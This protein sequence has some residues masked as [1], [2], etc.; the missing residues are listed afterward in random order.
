[1]SKGKSFDLKENPYFVYM[2]ESRKF[3]LRYSPEP[4]NNKSLIEKY[5]KS[6][7]PINKTL[8]DNTDELN[9]KFKLRKSLENKKSNEHELL[10]QRKNNTDLVQNFSKNY[11]TKKAFRKT[12]L[13]RR[14]KKSPT[15]PSKEFNGA[16]KS[17]YGKKEP[18]KVSIT[19]ETNSSHSSGKFPVIQKG[20]SIEDYLLGD[21]L[22]KGGYA[23]VRS[24]IHSPTGKV[25]A[26][27]V[28]NKSFLN[29]PSRL[30][31]LEKE[32]A[33]MKSLDHPSIVK[34]H[35]KIETLTQVIIVM[36]FVSSKS[37]LTHIKNKREKLLNEAEAKKIFAQLMDAINYCHQKRVA[38]RDVKLENILLDTN[39][40]AKLIDFGF[41]TA[42]ENG[43]K[44]SMFCGTPNYMAPEIVQHKEFSPAPADIWACGVVL[45]A[46]LYGNYPFNSKNKELYRK[47]TKQEVLLKKTVSKE[48][49]NLIRKMLHK[50]PNERPCAQEVLNHKWLA[51]Y[52]GPD[53]IDELLSGIK[54][55]L[56]VIF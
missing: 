20:G 39:N 46:M 35:Q 1:M 51:N 23:V 2:P 22:G 14:P 53:K 40:N 50:D 30:K 43:E 52:K 8:I 55:K 28:Y 6:L 3:K 27:K 10:T 11:E 44:M 41:S 13:F 19:P 37:L 45:F 21:I 38:H 31:S 9:K 54:T 18:R 29:K 25:F 7:K 5:R 47:I 15:S 48:A 17:L 24:A 36:E 34:F 56:K 49:R 4:T 33:V 26:L 12:Q 32:I 42:F 16:L